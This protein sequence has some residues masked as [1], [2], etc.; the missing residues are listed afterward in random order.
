MDL[1]TFPIGDWWDAESPSAA[2]RKPRHKNLGS[3]QELSR[4][5]RY[6][7]LKENRCRIKA[8]W[9]HSLWAAASGRGAVTPLWRPCRGLWGRPCRGGCRRQILVGALAQGPVSFHGKTLCAAGKKG[10]HKDQ[11]GTSEALPLLL[12]RGNLS[13]L[14]WRA[15]ESNKQI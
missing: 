15:V 5:S 10:M 13:W 8:G 11:E 2:S 7:G 14:I 4:G 9:G 1:L 12:L 6:K 3:R